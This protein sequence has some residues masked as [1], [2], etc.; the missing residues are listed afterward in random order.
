[1]KKP[2][3]IKGAGIVAVLL[4]WTSL[5]NSGLIKR[6]LDRPSSKL[7]LTKLSYS[8]ACVWP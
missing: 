2:Q 8:L 6:P 1:M 3:W 7:N 4:H 5:E